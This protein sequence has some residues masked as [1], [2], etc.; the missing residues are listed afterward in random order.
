MSL[1]P[2]LLP[3]NVVRLMTPEEQKRLGYVTPAAAKAKDD[4][5]REK[6]LHEQALALLRLRG[7]RF[8]LHSRMDRRSTVRVGTPDLLF[9]YRGQA[10]A[11]E[12]KRPGEVPIEAQR[13]CHADMIADGWRVKVADNLDDVKGWLDSLPGEQ[14]PPGKHQ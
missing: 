2:K 3:P 14:R 9:V 8:V 13:K 11:L 7:V 5:K 4:L 6:E 10:C 12:L 1:D